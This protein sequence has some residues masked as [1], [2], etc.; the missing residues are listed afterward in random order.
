MAFAE[1]P[2]P[3]GSGSIRCWGA[4]ARPVRGS[5][6][7]AICSID[8][9]AG[10]CVHS[11]GAA[12]GLYERG[13]FGARR[14]QRA[15]RIAWRHGGHG[16][17]IER[18]RGL[19]REPR[20]QLRNTRNRAQR[21][22]RPF[23]HPSGQPEAFRGRQAPPWYPAS[24][25]SS[26]G[27]ISEPDPVPDAG[28]GL[29]N[30]Q[31]WLIKYDGSG[32]RKLAPGAYA[33]WNADGSAIEVITYNSNCVPSLGIYPVGGGAYT[34]VSIPFVAGDGSFAW[35]PD[36]TKLSFYRRSAGYA[37]GGMNL[38]YT[39]DLYTLNAHGGR[40]TDIA[41]GLPQ[42]EPLSWVPDGTAVVI[43]RRPLLLG[44]L[45]SSKAGPIERINVT[46]KAVTQ[47]MPSANY[48]AVYVSPDGG[49]LAYIVY[50][51]TQWRTHVIDIRGPAPSKYTLGYYPDHDLGQTGAQDGSAVWGSDREHLAVLREQ[52][53]SQLG[54]STYAEY[55]WY[56]PTGTTGAWD[57]FA[58]A[59][60]TSTA[61]G[62]LD[63]SPDETIF[64]AS[65]ITNFGTGQPYYW[66]ILVGDTGGKSG[67]FLA[68]TTGADWLA[69]QPLP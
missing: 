52:P 59:L 49:L 12:G 67:I 65:T 44:A 53:D 22:R 61:D 4:V 36:G 46:T 21:H 10:D 23:G 43:A 14:Q 6:D 50:S 24:S 31:Y 41:P 60:L 55:Y 13:D 56:D 37:C 47:I 38:N 17:A 62:N 19:Q 63:W 69:W 28:Q 9:L 5:C 1:M 48:S 58:G 54:S 30:G 27:G 11:R 8:P 18:E 51:G 35:T 3:D 40:L 20:L 16:R 33:H 32:N 57:V 25:A 26:A 2:C 34:P 15:G 68:G 29:L 64:A 42:A 66:S 7:G 39:S 45:R